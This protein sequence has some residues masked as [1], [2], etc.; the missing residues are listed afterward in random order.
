MAAM[1]FRSLASTD[2]ASDGAGDI[3]RL[4]LLSL[5]EKAATA[6]AVLIRGSEMA[7]EPRQKESGE[8]LVTTLDRAVEE[9]IREEIAASRPDDSFF[10]EELPSLSGR[11]A[12]RWIVDPIDGTNNF[13][14]GLPH[15]SIS[16]AA[17]SQRGIEVGVVDA[18]ALEQR[19]T[20]RVGGGVRLN[21]RRL[22]TRLGPTPDLVD[23]VV[24]TGFASDGAAREVQMKQ[25]DR[26]LGAVRDVRCHG[27]ASLELCCV[28]SGQLDAYFES[29]LRIWDVAAAGLVATEA[30][31][32]ISG[33]PWSD[34]GTLVVAPP[35]L[36]DKLR[37][38]VDPRDSHG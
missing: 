25:L 30:G 10:G 35:A 15:W 28:A 13:I 4:E 31:L 32:H 16:I 6:A 33:Q 19:Y 29:H 24:A 12:I 11:S 23:A 3:D 26:V 38:L 21:G 18:P 5:A 2:E 37:G 34:T 36:A 1:V 17:R 20:A 8:G 22:T 7:I 14:A 9:C 27:A